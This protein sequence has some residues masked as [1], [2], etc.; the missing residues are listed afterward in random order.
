[1]DLNELELEGANGTPVALV[2]LAVGDPIDIPSPAREV[3]DEEAP[4]PTSHRSEEPVSRI[5]LK[6]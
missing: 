6:V 3:E 2:E 5:T 4:C 1:M